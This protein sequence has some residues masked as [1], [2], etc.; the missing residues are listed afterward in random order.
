[1]LLTVLW[2]NCDSSKKKLQKVVGIDYHKVFFNIE[3]KIV[4]CV[5]LEIFI[6]K[7]FLK[8]NPVQR[9]NLTFYLL[10]L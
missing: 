2:G 8:Y 10:N 3:V 6:I 4:G 1:M 9:T 5:K 7:Y